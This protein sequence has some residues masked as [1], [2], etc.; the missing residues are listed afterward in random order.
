M[1]RRILTLVTV[2]MMLFSTS[3][4]CS[5]ECTDDYEFGEDEQLDFCVLNIWAE[6][7]VDMPTQDITSIKMVVDVTDFSG[8]PIDVKLYSRESVSWNT[9][10][11]E[12]QSLAGD[13]T[14]TFIVNMGEENKFP[15]EN[16]CTIYV[17]DVR[18]CKADEDPAGEE[19][20][21]S[22]ISCHMKLV[23]V[24]YNPADAGSAGTVDVSSDT[25]GSDEASSEVGEATEEAVATVDQAEA[26]TQAPKEDDEKSGSA[27]PVV[28][29]VIVIV[30]VAAVA[31]VL[32]SKKKNS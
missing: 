28:I 5:A 6:S 12:P 9:W 31:G 24:E 23:S 2:L 18:C 21:E 16:L 4:L 26:T 1:K 8:D 7:F 15:G 32:V 14:Y 22:G 27:L 30:V 29:I 10:A 19:L 20:D 17:K 3:V 25:D 11:S 13:G